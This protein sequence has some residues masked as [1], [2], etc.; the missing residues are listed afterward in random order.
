MKFRLLTL[1][2]AI[3]AASTQ[4]LA[5]APNFLDSRA[6]AMGGVGVA[7]ARPAAASYYNPAMLAVKQTSKSDGFGLILPSI[8]ALASDEDEML[9]TVDNFED[10]FVTPFEKSIDDLETA[11]DNG[12]PVVILQ[13]KQ[14]FDD[15][16]VAIN[17]EL[18]RIN[19]DKV[20]V[21]LGVGVSV[22]VPGQTLGVG[23]FISGN[24]SISASLNYED[25]NY[26]TNVLP[27][28]A[29]AAILANDS[30]QITYDPDD[31]DN[32]LQSNVRAVGS[33]TSQAGVTLAHNFTFGSRDYALG[34]SPK[35]VD[36]RAYDFS[37]DVDDFESDDISDSKVS[38]TSF[39]FDIGL[40]THLDSDN[41]WL[42]GLSVLNAISNDI[43]T[44]DIVIAGPTPIS[45]SGLTI[46]LK[47]TITTGISYSGMSYIVA[48]DL[49]LTKTDAVTD[50]NGNELIPGRQIVAI[51][52]EY[53][54]FE[55]IQFRLGAR[56]NLEG[57]SD[58]LL[59]TGFG[60]TVFGASLELAAMGN[61]DTLGASFQ[62]G[63]TF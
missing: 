21:D 33:A 6:F 5:G 14:D 3:A 8:S 27:A 55:T 20:L 28:Q 9:D 26:L 40:A 15:K 35:I 42:F 44:N 37:A 47:P 53:D 60:F 25:E 46:E 54:L 56:H 57:D 10:D 49:E 13:A 52:A 32:N 51:G 45:V 38:D 12:V 48:A 39:N 2:A 31:P 18:N 17:S 58:T 41:R 43:K 1:G 62:I 59:T 16:I 29:N 19:R 24:A 22:Q 63:S 11:I 61:S 36:F 23:V 4:A 7:S 50:T 34:I 30:S